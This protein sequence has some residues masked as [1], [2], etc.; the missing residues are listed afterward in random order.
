MLRIVLKADAAG[1]AAL[2]VLLMLAVPA[3]LVFDL[4]AAAVGAVVLGCAVVLG[5]FGC[6]I[7]GVLAYAIATGPPELLDPSDLEAPSARR[8][9]TQP[10]RTEKLA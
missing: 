6:A 7:A 10:V 2:P 9:K 3:L 8:A 5:S 1:S 4:P